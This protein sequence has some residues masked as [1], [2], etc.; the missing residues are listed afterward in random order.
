MDKTATLLTEVD[1]PLAVPVPVKGADGKDAERSKLVMRRPKVRHTK[2]L[3]V[4][5]GQ[6]V[7]SA[8]L[9]TRS[10][11]VAEISQEIDGR[12]LVAELLTKLLAREALDELTAIIADM[13][14]EDS[15]II[16]ELD[17]VDLMGVG[18]AFLRFFPALQSSVSGVLQGTSDTTTG[19]SRRS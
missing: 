6:D 3:A 14:G 2:R 12:A 16:D 7:V 1:I 15:A 9:D 5:I 8:L 13:C 4:L 18:T 19:G 10:G 11:T 17:L